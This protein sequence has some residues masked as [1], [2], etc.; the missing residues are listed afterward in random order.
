MCHH[1][2]NDWCKP[3]MVRS[4]PHSNSKTA[5]NANSRDT[6]HVAFCT[7][8]IGIRTYILTLSTTGAAGYGSSPQSNSHATLSAAP[9]SSISIGTCSILKRVDMLNHRVNAPRSQSQ[10]SLRATFTHC[11]PLR[12]HLHRQPH[13]DMLYRRCVNDRCSRSD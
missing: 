7:I 9:P 6:L 12:L 5:V 10:P 1:L 11:S 8:T 2:A 13:E 3:V 4:S